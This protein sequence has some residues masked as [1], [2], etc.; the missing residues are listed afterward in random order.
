ML[1]RLV[2]LGACALS[3]LQSTGIAGDKLETIPKVPEAGKEFQVLL[4]RDFAEQSIAA[5]ASVAKYEWAIIVKAGNDDVTPAAAGLTLPLPNAPVLKIN[6]ARKET[7]YFFKLT[8]TVGDVKEEFGVLAV[9]FGREGAEARL[10]IVLSARPREALQLAP[11]PAPLP[12]LPP[13]NSFG[14]DPDSVPALAAS[15]PSSVR[16]TPPAFPAAPEVSAP[17]TSPRNLTFISQA[18]GTSVAGIT[19]PQ[20]FDLSNAGLAK[21]REEIVTIIEKNKSGADPVLAPDSYFID[22]FNKPRKVGAFTRTLRK[23]DNKVV[24]CNEISKV[25]FQF[26]G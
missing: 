12:I 26:A 9:D 15:V 5:K 17:A 20:E 19:I 25:M 10:P 23:T 18:G 22:A 11:P 8:K 16:E 6:A 3:C 2:L 21:A 7:I 14:D 24:V 4:L 13:S 1:F